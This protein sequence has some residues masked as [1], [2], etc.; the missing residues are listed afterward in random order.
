[1]SNGRVCLGIEVWEDRAQTLPLMEFN[2]QATSQRCP[3]S[4]LKTVH[5]NLERF[6]SK[7]L[8]CSRFHSK[9]ETWDNFITLTGVWV[10]LCLGYEQI[11]KRS[12]V[13]RHPLCLCG[14]MPADVGTVPSIHCM[15]PIAH[16]FA[17]NFSAHELNCLGLPCLLIPLCFLTISMYFRYTYHKCWAELGPP[18]SLQQKL[19]TPVLKDVAV[20]RDRTGRGKDENEH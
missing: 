19:L 5:L 13:T 1:M 7:K 20:F 14:D 16:Y 17:I 8:L 15:L 12:P 3:R 10:K 18:K 4:R 2:E 6:P 11:L 9:D